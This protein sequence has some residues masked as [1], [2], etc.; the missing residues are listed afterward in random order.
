MSQ[1]VIAAYVRIPFHFARKGVAG[2]QPDHLAA[3]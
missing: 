3:A 2:V 1:A